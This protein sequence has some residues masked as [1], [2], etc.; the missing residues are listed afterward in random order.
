MS[1]ARPCLQ[2]PNLRIESWP[3]K[4]AEGR[5]EADEEVL[6]QMGLVE[7]VDLGVNGPDLP[8]EKG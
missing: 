3:E 2:T 6:H 4:G 7:V 8:E 1:P 5:N